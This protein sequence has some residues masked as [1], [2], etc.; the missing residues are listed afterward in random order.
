MN[1]LRANCELLHQGIQLLSRH[2]ER[3]F[4]ATDPASYGSGIGAHFRHVLDHYRSFLEGIAV[5]LIDYDNRERDTSE[6]KMLSVAL[7]SLSELSRRMEAAEVDVGRSVQVKVCASTKGDDLHSVSS[8]GRELQFLVSHTV[9][10]FALVAIASRMQG[11]Y[12]EEGFG[13]APSTL[14][15]LNS[16]QR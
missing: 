7:E 16:I 15:F 11:I 8:F 4:N 5:G 12:P 3:T 1:L 9:H 14:K 2:D 10:H 13:V 6:E